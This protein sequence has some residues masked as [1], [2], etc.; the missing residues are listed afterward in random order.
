MATG[1]AGASPRGAQLVPRL[2]SGLPCTAR[3]SL[4]G[5]SADGLVAPVA[6]TRPALWE[7]GRHDYKERPRG[8]HRHACP[9]AC[10][11]ARP[12]RPI[13]K[14]PSYRPL[15]A[16]WSGSDLTDAARDQGSVEHT[17]QAERQ[18]GQG[19]TG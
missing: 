18:Q 8:A 1:D 14:L 3:G 4:G 6:F 2:G 19:L 5:L 9:V 7:R 17:Q 10:S 16:A 13:L 11:H 12:R 15:G